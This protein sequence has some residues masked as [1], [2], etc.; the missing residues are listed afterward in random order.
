LFQFNT[1]QELEEKNDLLFK[2]LWT[3]FLSKI[4]HVA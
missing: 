1:K 2:Q 4:K 3:S